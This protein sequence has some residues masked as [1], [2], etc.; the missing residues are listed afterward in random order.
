CIIAEPEPAAIRRAVETLRDRAI[1]RDEIRSRTMA[2][3][4]PQG[5]GLMESLSALR[6]RMGSAEPM[7]SQ[8]PFPGTGS[9]RRYGTVRQ[10][11]REI[12]APAAAAGR[13]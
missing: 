4:W 2:K 9:L 3:V 1:P 11:A 6:E 5:R 10:H 12:A 13:S 8:W 7:L